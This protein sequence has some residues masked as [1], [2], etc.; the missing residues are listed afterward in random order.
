MYQPHLSWIGLGWRWTTA[1]C[2]ARLVFLCTFC[3]IPSSRYQENK[4]WK[5]RQSI[6]LKK[7]ERLNVGSL[8]TVKMHPVG[9]LPTVKMHPVGTLPTVKMHPVGSIPWMKILNFWP[10]K[11]ILWVKKMTARD[12]YSTAQCVL[13]F[14]SNPLV[15]VCLSVHPIGWAHSFWRFI[16]AAAPHSIG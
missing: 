10:Y 7:R 5:L 4:V 8:P 11:W 16:G 14:C 9:R 6:G 13:D 3:Y 2:A 1:P 12:V 15:C